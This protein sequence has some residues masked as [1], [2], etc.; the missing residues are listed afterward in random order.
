ML[1]TIPEN[2]PTDDQIFKSRPEGSQNAKHAYIARY[3]LPNGDFK[4]I[5]PEEEEGDVDNTGKIIVPISQ[6]MNRHFFGSYGVKKVQVGDKIE[7]QPWVK[8]GAFYTHDYSYDVNKEKWVFTLKK[9]EDRGYTELEVSP[10]FKKVYTVP[11]RIEDLKVTPTQVLYEP[12][13]PILHTEKEQSETTKK[14]LS[15]TVDEEVDP[16]VNIAKLSTDKNIRFSKIPKELIEKFGGSSKVAAEQN[17]LD[18]KQKRP[19]TTLITLGR[20]NKDNPD[21]RDKL[22]G[23]WGDTI[24]EMARGVAARLRDTRT[25]RYMENIDQGNEL[26]ERN[27]KSKAGNFIRNLV[28]DLI[29]EGQLTLWE[30]AVHYQADTDPDHRFDKLASTRI[31]NM[32]LR[33]TTR[34]GRQYGLQLP[35]TSLAY[36]EAEHHLTPK[37]LSP[38]EAYEYKEVEREAKIILESKIKELHPTYQKI[39]SARLWMDTPEGEEKGE[40]EE[41]VATKKRVDTKGIGATDRRRFAKDTWQRRYTGKGS[42]LEKYPY[43]VDPLKFKEGEAEDLTQLDEKTARTRLQLW[44]SEGLRQLVEK[45]DDVREGS[46]VH[47]WLQLETK[48]AQN[49]KRR[50]DERQRHDITPSLR[51]GESQNAADKLKEQMI[52][53]FRRKREA[54]QNYNKPPTAVLPPETNRHPIGFTFSR[55]TLPFEPNRQHLKGSGMPK[56]LVHHIWAELHEGKD[57]SLEAFSNRVLYPLWDHEKNGEYYQEQAVGAVKQVLEKLQEIGVV[58]SLPWKEDKITK[59]FIFYMEKSEFIDSFIVLS[60][61]YDEYRDE[62]L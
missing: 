49:H 60:N 59:S 34:I 6:I 52:A 16:F 58:T 13:T 47:R 50:F 15:L 19:L 55:K 39:I 29:A 33:E 22:L 32:M 24:R 42:I 10:K 20:W 18:E 54:L 7:L 48:L 17:F 26:D 38:E 56:A 30:N 28:N 40:E 62:K 45:L 61:I 4:R 23:E 46:I 53:D 2:Y 51:T 36:D 11:G 37:E 25:Y 9:R 43:W 27:Q 1:V 44:F 57:S 14:V 31:Y 8:P 12:K 3:R 35:S 21:D 5:Y 41:L